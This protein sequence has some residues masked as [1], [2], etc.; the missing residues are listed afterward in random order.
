MKIAKTF[1]YIGIVWGLCALIASK[2]AIGFNHTPSLSGKV[3]LV[4]KHSLP[5]EKFQKAVFLHNGKLHIKHIVG[6]QGDE[7]SH[8]DDVLFIN[9]KEFGKIKRL[10]LQNKPLI[11]ILANTQTLII[12]ANY[13]FAW[14][15]HKDSFDSRYK[16]VGLIHQTQIVGKGYEIL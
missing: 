14:T 7:I 6:F 9:G 15:D 8:K 5:I 12:P 10:S 11:P 4:V 13:Y 1:I 16:E 2:F 3:F